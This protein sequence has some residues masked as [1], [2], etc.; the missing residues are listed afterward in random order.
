M[1]VD[2]KELRQGTF[3]G[4]GV[5]PQGDPDGDG[6]SNLQEYLAGTDPNDPTSSP[7]RITDIHLE[8]NSVRVTWVPGPGA[9]NALQVTAGAPDESY[10]TNGFT[11]L[12][13]VTNAVGSVTSALS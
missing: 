11:D 9:T 1:P 2:V 5:D 7:F 10:Q 12:F 13:I 8:D 4:S 3:D 6:Q